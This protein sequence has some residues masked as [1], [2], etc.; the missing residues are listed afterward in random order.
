MSGFVFSGWASR[1]AGIKTKQ[2]W[3]WN[4]LVLL[5]SL[6]RLQRHQQESVPFAST[7]HQP[8]SSLRPQD[9]DRLHPLRFHPEAQGKVKLRLASALNQA[10][11]QMA[12]VTPD[13]FIQLQMPVFMASSQKDNKQHYFFLACQSPETLFNKHVLG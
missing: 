1:F 12:K 2:H 13:L 11:Q 9:S 7:K 3:L 6:R 5:C 8:V 4:S 10:L